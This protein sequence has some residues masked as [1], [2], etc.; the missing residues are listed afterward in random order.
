[1]KHIL[2]TR[3]VHIE[4]AES[5]SKDRIA[6]RIQEAD[7]RWKAL[8]MKVKTRYDCIRELMPVCSQYSEAFDSLLAWLTT[9]NS[10][11]NAILP[12]A[13]DQENLIQQQRV[14]QV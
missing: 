12:I 8:S 3:H 9:A 13:N 6:S 5:S 14:I 2:D 4:R 1:M 11:V 7:R 10:E